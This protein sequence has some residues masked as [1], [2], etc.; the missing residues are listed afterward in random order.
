MKYSNDNEDINLTI[1]PIMQ[2]L[3]ML[4]P[5]PP[6]RINTI[7]TLSPHTISFILP[8]TT[9]NKNSRGDGNIHNE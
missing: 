7:T 2:M 8:V 3:C 5:D 6:H 1:F 4:T 9:S